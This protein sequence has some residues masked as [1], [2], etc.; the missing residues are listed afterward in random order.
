VNENLQA[1]LHYERAE[2]DETSVARD[3]FEQ[4]RGWYDEARAETTIVEPNAMTLA[5]V[6]ADGRP[7]ARIVLLRGFDE[8]GFAFFTNYESRKGHELGVHPDAA[9]LFYWANLERQVRIEG[10]V[11][12]LDAGE[13]DAYF[14]QRPRGH[15][16]GAWASPQSRP[17]ADRAALD[18]AVHAVEERFEGRE[19]ERPPFWGGF[20]VAPVRFE[21]WQGRR[22]R[23]HDRIVY[24]R[25]PGAWRILRLGP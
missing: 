21:F 25:E 8:R 20:R 16:V 7:S 15:R 23:I 5:T 22:N 1:R 13:S 2:L 24:E 19:V 17:V 6:G 14:A 3:P 4:F 12:R 11:A 10:L 9:L 18:A